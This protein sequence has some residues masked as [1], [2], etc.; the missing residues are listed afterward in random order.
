MGDPVMV[1]DLLSDAGTL[2]GRLG[3]AL[4]DEQWLDAYLFA[5]GLGQLADDRL[6][7]DPFLLHRAASYL[8]G[9]ASRPA[10]F[11][12]A[13]AA[14]FGAV[15]RANT[16]P[17][18]RRLLRA[19]Q[20][21]AE[22]T[23]RLAGQVLAPQRTGDLTPLLQ[24]SLPVVA[25]VAG[26]RLRMPACFHSF[27]QHPDDVRWLVRAFRQ[28]HPVDGRP[29]CVVGVRTSGSY[30]APLHATALQNDGQERVEVLTYRPGQP[31]L[32]AERSVLSGIARAGGL[33]LVVDD[34]PASGSS[35]AAAARAVARAG[36][37]DSR[38]VFLLSLFG[39][40]QQLPEVLRDWS[41]VV[42]PW[43]DWSVHR[44]LAAQPVRQALTGLVQPD[45]EV[46][47]VQPLGTPRSAGER[48]HLRAQFAVRLFDRRT[49]AETHQRVLVEGAGIGYLGRQSVAVAHALPGYVTHVYGFADG[50]LYR[51]WLPSAP[52]PAAG[53][54]L[55]STVGRSAMAGTVAAYVD[56]R[57]RALP[58]PAASVAGLGGRDPV[59]EVAA[60]VL[61]GQCGRLALPARPLLLE[62][63]V[64]RLLAHE[65][66]TVLDSKTD[67]RHWLP[68]PAAAGELRKVDFYQRSYGHLDLAC[69][70]PVFDLAG[71]A[72]DPPTPSFEKELRQAYQHMSGQQ[73]D[74]E[75][76][77]LYR[78]AQL[79]RLGQAG[80]VARPDVLRRST[81]AVHD[82]LAAL[83]L[84][85]LP[86]ATGPLCA[87][88]IDGV[89]ECDQLGFSATSPTGMLALRALIAHG[90]RP[91]L[92][93]GRSVPEVRD[94]C[95]AF[96]L[97]GGV[98]EYGTAIYCGGEPTDLRPPESGA[99]LDRIRKELSGRPGV[100]V[101]LD[102]HYAVRARSGS[103]P[104]SAELIREIPAFNDPAVR[105][106]HGDGQTDVTVAGVDKGTGLAALAAALSNPECA[107]AI[108]DSLPDIP[109]LACATLARAPRNA[110]FGSAGV[111]IRRTRRAYQAGLSDACADLLGHR[112]GRCPVC[113]AA[114]FTPRTRTMLAILDLRANGLA[115]LPAGTAALVALAVTRS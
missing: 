1:T 52:E 68:D 19:R 79:W 47:E 81:A 42:Q 5:A 26:D 109:L 36:V 2:S 39:T 34:P 10:H 95:L 71:A 114:P 41:A 69:Y 38:I 33:V 111:G 80:D 24:A 108:G 29:L 32:R 8:R 105:I 70:D 104:L 88:D 4:R 54:A 7:P 100:R 25:S 58:A 77:L 103:G 101:D 94:R 87:I 15:T 61:S 21:L 6:H 59:W 53:S 17:G 65:H 35:L 27:D 23:L 49:G 50:L 73:V 75:R 106:V 107:L 3:D 44:R 89:L 40:S 14:G 98:A 60:K 66:P 56:A 78:L 51:D 83:Y 84:R 96:G 72:A 92:A 11:A 64:R 55:V 28:Q 90:Y 46:R 20:P 110:R 13:V 112:P 22:L 99:L 74:G 62:P 86:A 76:W 67:L 113:R 82:Y 63:L 97:A 91:V 12:G 57:R 102:Y 43:A 30:L 9:L 37:P 16:M 93:T 31:F 18:G 45:L 85:D 115:T 48:G